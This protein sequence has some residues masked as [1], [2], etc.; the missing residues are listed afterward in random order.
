M[1]RSLYT[2]MKEHITKRMS[3]AFD[4]VVESNDLPDKLPLSSIA[5]HLLT[6]RHTVNPIDTV[7]IDYRVRNMYWNSLKWLQSKTCNR[8]FANRNSFP[9]W[10]RQLGSCGCKIYEPSMLRLIVFVADYN[11]F[12]SIHLTTYGD[13]HA[14]RCC[15]N[16]SFLMDYSV[17]CSS[18]SHHKQ[19]PSSWYYTC[20]KQIANLYNF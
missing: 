6:T 14:D 17:W 7:K 13:I 4:G 3:R 15:V 8:R 9:S 18:R 2:K 11:A 12:C 1:C 5:R 16:P 19:W 10:Y 20:V